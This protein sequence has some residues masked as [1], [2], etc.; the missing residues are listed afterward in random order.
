V[1]N[2]LNYITLINCKNGQGQYSDGRKVTGIYFRNDSE[3]LVTTA[4]SR[5]R[6][7]SLEVTIKEL[8]RKLGIYTKGQI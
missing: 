5:L 2:R 1:K 3:A 7:L 4:D 8:N 6:L